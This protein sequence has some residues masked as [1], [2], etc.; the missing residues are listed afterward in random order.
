MH[1]NKILL[2]KFG[3]LKDS[4]LEIIVKN[5]MVHL[6]FTG[7]EC[8]KNFLI[9]IYFFYR[10]NGVQMRICMPQGRWTEI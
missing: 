9:C 4:Y 6:P 3:F 5:E 1:P 8:S 2:L 10:S 7:K